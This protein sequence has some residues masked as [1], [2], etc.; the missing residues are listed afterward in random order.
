MGR[1]CF[2]LKLVAARRTALL[3]LAFMTSCVPLMCDTSASAYPSSLQDGDGTIDWMFGG[4]LI[5][6]FPNTV[7]STS[8]EQLEAFVQKFDMLYAKGF[9]LEDLAVRS[10]NGKWT[11]FVGS[12]PLIAAERLHSRGSGMDPKTICCTWMSRI[13][14]VIGKDAAPLTDRFKIRG[15]LSI[16]G[17]VSWYGGKFIGRRCAN[18]ERFTETHL[19]AAA[20]S[21]PFGTLVRITVPVTKRSVVIRIADRFG[22]HKGRALDVSPAAAEILGIKRIGVANAKIEV[23]GKVGKIG[24]R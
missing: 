7:S 19:S 12:V 3:V 21:L 6:R 13:Y 4:E 17:K 20:K 16:N 11:L 22:E 24:G 1:I 2:V 5:W 15:G 8:K 10:H 23:I 9:D 14:E 18:G